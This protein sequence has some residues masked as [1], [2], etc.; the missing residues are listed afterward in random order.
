L[1][2][3]AAVSMATAD[4]PDRPA[5]SSAGEISQCEKWIRERPYHS[6]T[7]SRILAISA[8]AACFDGEI[9]KES[10]KPILTWLSRDLSPDSHLLLAV[11]SGGGDAGAGIDVMDKLQSANATVHVVDLCASSC[12]NYFFAGARHRSVSDGALLLFHGGYSRGSREGIIAEIA[13][14]QKSGTAPSAVNWHETRRSIL[15]DFDRNMA[16]QDALYA[17]IGVNDAIVHGIDGV[18]LDA[19]ND[20]DCD[21]ARAALREGLF[22]TVPQLAALGIRIEHGRPA[23][24]PRDVNRMLVQMGKEIEFCGVPHPIFER[25]RRASSR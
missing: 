6:K 14:Y 4:V 18:D 12:A 2:F 19:L 15:T 5:P 20:A 24:E 9:S 25:F 23:T 10:V 13:K 8:D 16:R 3:V 17:R 21:P 11:R 7:P 1:L 22:F